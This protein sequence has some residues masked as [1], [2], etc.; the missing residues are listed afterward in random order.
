VYSSSTISRSI[1]SS[2][3]DDRHTVLSS[4]SITSTFHVNVRQPHPCTRVHKHV[5]KLHGKLS[6]HSTPTHERRACTD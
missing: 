3:N 2:M 5:N 6:W 1:D 4:T